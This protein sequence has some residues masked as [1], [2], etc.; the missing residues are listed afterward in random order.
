MK[1]VGNRET[2]AQTILCVAYYTF[3]PRVDAT[4]PLSPAGAGMQDRQAGFVQHCTQQKHMHV[5]EPVAQ[6]E[7]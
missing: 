6:R 7:E 4:R 1:P 2:V 5:N 3:D